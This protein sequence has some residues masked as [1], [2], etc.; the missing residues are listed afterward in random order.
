[1]GLAT[2]AGDA[3]ATGEAG[4]GDRAT[5]ELA[6][7]TAAGD[8]AGAAEAGVPADAAPPDGGRVGVGEA[9]P[10][11]AVSSRSGPKPLPH[12]RRAARRVT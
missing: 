1:M 5:G 10:P 9:D 2:R 12:A 4:T 3:E 7:P 11:Q 8:D 6:G